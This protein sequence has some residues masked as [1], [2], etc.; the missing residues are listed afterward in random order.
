MMFSGKVCD[1]FAVAFLDLT[2]ICGFNTIFLTLG[3]G[4]GEHSLPAA[5]SA[6]AF[7]TM[8]QAV[9]PAQVTCPPSQSPTVKTNQSSPDS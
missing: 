9:C 8:T 7:Q 6:D 5:L 3:P 2:V 4:G 1:M